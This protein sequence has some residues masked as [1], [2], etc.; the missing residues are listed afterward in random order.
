[1]V[2]NHLAQLNDSLA[3]GAVSGVEDDA[4]PWLRGKT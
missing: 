1:M 4:V 3:D 2:N